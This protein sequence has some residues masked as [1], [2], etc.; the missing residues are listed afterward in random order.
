MIIPA[1]ICGAV[2]TSCGSDKVQALEKDE[3]VYLKSDN[4][5]V[6]KYNVE[7]GTSDIASVK[8]IMGYQSPDSEWHYLEFSAKYENGSFELNLPATIPD[9]YLSPSS[10]VLLY[11]DDILLSDIHAKNTFAMILAHNSTE[12]NIGGFRFS[13]GKWNMGFMYADRSYTEKGFSKGGL[14]YDC[15]YKKGWNIVYWY[16]NETNSK[17]TTQKPK[18]EKFKCNLSYNSFGYGG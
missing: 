10:N 5:L 12:S 1:L 9:E 15:S 17:K 6:I 14:G 11:E 2:F 4:S 8:V 3:G 16:W 7:N 13:S 18:N